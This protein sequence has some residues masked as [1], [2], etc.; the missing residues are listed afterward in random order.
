[1]F[2]RKKIFIIILLFSQFISAQKTIRGVVQDEESQEPIIGVNILLLGSETGTVS[3]VKGSFE[4]AIPDDT[5]SVLRLS[6]IGYNTSEVTIDSSFSGILILTPA[7]IKGSEIEVVGVK[8]KTEM[9]VASSVDMLDI[10]EIEIQGARDLGSALRRVS[11]VKMDY[12]TSGKQTISIRGSNATDVAV[13]LD[14]VRLNDANTGVADLSTIDLNSLE[15]V[16]VIKGGNSSLFGSG[17]I[18]G[19]VNMESKTAEK[20][21]VYINTGVGQTYDDDMDLSFGATTVFGPAGLGGRYTAKARAFGGRTITTSLFANAFGGVDFSSGRLDLRWF[22]LN[23][24]LQF[25]SGS[26]DSGDSLSILSMN[27][28]GSILGTSGWKLLAGLKD[29]SLNQNFFSS[30]N[31]YLSDHSQNI[32]ISKLMNWRDFEGTVQYEAE[33]QTFDGDKS[34]FNINGDPTVYHIADMKRNT[35][36]L[37]FVTRW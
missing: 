37:A 5:S 4:L 35:D 27:Y 17:A 24:N 26:V 30:L 12:S 18:G 32:H 25:P 11:S 23:K 36:A 3:D 9:D 29:W 19:V 10:A 15:Q 7:V 13:F 28:R 33:Y 16:Q 6:H 8:S 2:T 21:S 20:N 22:Q 1:M 14:G 31:E 34:Y